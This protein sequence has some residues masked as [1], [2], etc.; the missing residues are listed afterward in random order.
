MAPNIVL[1]MRRDSL[2]FLRVKWPVSATLLRY[3]SFSSSLVTS[4]L[5]FVLTFC[6]MFSDW[7]AILF[8]LLQCLWVGKCMGGSNV[9]KI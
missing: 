5:L 7:C 4:T 9:L 3:Q 2:F 8:C 6:M 1:V